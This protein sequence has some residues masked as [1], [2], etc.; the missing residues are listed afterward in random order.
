MPQLDAEQQGKRGNDEIYHRFA[1]PV[2][3]YLC[4]HVS[5]VQDAE[6]IL[7][8]VLFAVLQ[9][10]KFPTLTETQQRAWLLHVAK[11]KMIDYYRH[12]NL[13]NT[14]PLEQ[15][16]GLEGSELTP[17]HAV[18]QQERY[19]SLTQAIARLSPS[20]QQFIALRYAQGL[21]LVTIAAVLGKPQGTVRKWLARTLKQLRASIDKA[22]EE[23]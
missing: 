12:V 15:A 17:E 23:E 7:F 11:N 10:K 4:Q 22:R 3:T 18:E 6:D 8:D 1:S 2:L 19:A 21:R 5:N 13:I 16:N 14:L 20:Q 9:D